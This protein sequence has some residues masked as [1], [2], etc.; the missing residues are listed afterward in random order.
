MM[1]LLFDLRLLIKV[2]DAKNCQNVGLSLL[3]K[4]FNAKNYQNVICLLEVDEFQDERYVTKIQDNTYVFDD[5]M[6]YLQNIGE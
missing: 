4:V 3:S 1:N 2:F 5:L 6:I